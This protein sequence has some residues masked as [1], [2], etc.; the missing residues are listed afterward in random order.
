MTKALPIIPARE[1]IIEVRTPMVS[2]EKLP[3]RIL[4]RE[5]TI[6]PETT[7]DQAMDFKKEVTRISFQRTPRAIIKAVTHLDHLSQ[8][9]KW[10]K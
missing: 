5:T 6:A 3:E 9:V 2:E 8:R 1:M 7:L 10:P 4:V